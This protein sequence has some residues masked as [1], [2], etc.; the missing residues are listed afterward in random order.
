MATSHK[1]ICPRC[2]DTMIRER[3]DT[4]ASPADIY[5]LLSWLAA[6]P[7]EQFWVVCFDTKNHVRSQHLLYQGTVNAAM[8]RPAEVFREAVTRTHPAIAIVH[9]H[10]SG[11]PTPSPE[12]METTRR[13]VEAGKLLDID[14][15]DHLVIGAGRFVSMRERRLGFA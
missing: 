4:V 9:N 2:Q 10:P 15:L 8:I 3:V 13:I 6:E 5:R 11:D 1:P 14:V 12:D 7:Q